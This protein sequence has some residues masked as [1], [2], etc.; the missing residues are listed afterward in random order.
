MPSIT[1]YTEM[2]AKVILFNTC[3][4]IILDMKFGGFKAQQVYY[5]VALLGKYYV[6][7]VNLQQIW[8]IQSVSENLIVLIHQLV[9]FVWEHF[10]NPTEQGVNTGQWCKKEDC[11][12]LL[13][14]RFENSAFYSRG[15]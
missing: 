8:N 1:S 15:A 13:Q 5:T 7:R 6:D 4:K 10:Q 2:I 9:N 3:D 12:S 14:K 11:W